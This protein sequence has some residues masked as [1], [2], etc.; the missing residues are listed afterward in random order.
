MY[1]PRLAWITLTHAHEVP[2][3]SRSLVLGFYMCSVILVSFL[4]VLNVILVGYDTKFALYKDPN[5][6]RYDHWWSPKYLPDLLRIRANAGDCELGKLSQDVILKTNSSLPLFSYRFKNSY[7]FEQ[8][9]NGG[10][11]VVTRFLDGPYQANPLSSCFVSEMGLYY[12]AWWQNSRVIATVTCEPTDS[13][14]RFFKFTTS[15]SASAVP[16]MR[17]DSSLDYFILDVHPDKTAINF[18]DWLFQDFDFKVNNTSRFNV[19]GVLDALAGD[20]SQIGWLQSSP[21][22]GTERSSMPDMAFFG[23]NLTRDERSLEDSS[24][25]QLLTPSTWYTQFSYSANRTILNFMVAI[26]DAIHTYQRRPEALDP[27]DLTA[28]CWTQGCLPNPNL[29][30][31]ETLREDTGKLSYNSLILPIVQPDPMPISVIDMT[32]FCP[33]YASCFNLE[34][35]FKFSKFTFVYFVGFYSEATM[36]GEV[37]TKKWNS[38]HELDVGEYIAKRWGSNRISTKGRERQRETEKEEK[39]KQEELLDKVSKTARR[40]NKI[41]E[42]THCVWGEEQEIEPEEIV[43]SCLESWRALQVEYS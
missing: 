16:Y 9:E 8:S 28:C 42:R 14:P 12:E 30:W 39:D 43:F 21:L 13:L 25:I 11:T 20:I 18:E 2:Y 7:I 32:Y 36:V 35:Y 24:R 38:K 37:L 26:R 27:E 22:N 19:L 4:I 33:V 23:W 17:P 6:T 10:A 15:Y 34:L 40:S 3:N 41:K 31:A 29:T 5:I 1:R